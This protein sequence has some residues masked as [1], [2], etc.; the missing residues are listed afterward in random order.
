ET[1]GGG[2]GGGTP[3]T[4]TSATSG[5]SASAS[6]SGSAS[7]SASASPSGGGGSLLISLLTLA[8]LTCD[9]TEVSATIDVTSN[10]LTAG[11]LTYSWYYV[12]VTG[13]QHTIGTPGTET[14][15]AG[16]L[17]IQSFTESESFGQYLDEDGWGIAI[18]TSP[19]AV[20]VTLSAPDPISPSGCLPK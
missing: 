12:D 1:G 2:T 19:A 6:P 18:S 17:T 10:G 7:P 16:I 14:I 13:A 3:V 11:T 4:S 20:K 9:Y 8:D 5:T 15:P